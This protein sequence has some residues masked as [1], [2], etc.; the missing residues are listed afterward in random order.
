MSVDLYNH[1]YLDFGSD[2]EA[3]V[4]HAITGKTSGRAVG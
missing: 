4:R 2:A 1:V 3:A